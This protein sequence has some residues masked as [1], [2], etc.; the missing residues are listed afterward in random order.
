MKE[1]EYN[2]NIIEDLGL[3]EMQVLNIISRWYV[4]GMMPDIIQNEDGF[5]LDELVDNIFWDLFEDE[6]L[7]KNIKL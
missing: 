7:I 4:N 1:L 2:E 6:K 3:T 5:E